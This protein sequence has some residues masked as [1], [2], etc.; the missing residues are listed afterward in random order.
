[1]CKSGNRRYKLKPSLLRS[2]ML[3]K[4]IVVFVYRIEGMPIKF[5]P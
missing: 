4:N 5:M 3:F 1:M 2:V